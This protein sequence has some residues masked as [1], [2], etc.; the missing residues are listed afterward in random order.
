M[1]NKEDPIPG[2]HQLPQEVKEKQRL[3]NTCSVPVTSTL[4][5]PGS[6][7]DAILG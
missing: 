2:L 7:V 3:G 5:T 6:I 4:L 1:I